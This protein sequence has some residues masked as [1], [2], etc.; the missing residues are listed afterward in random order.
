MSERRP[1]RQDRH[2][3]VTERPLTVLEAAEYLSVHPQTIYNLVQKGR[4]RPLR[5]GNRLRFT[6]ESLDR[7]MRGQREGGENA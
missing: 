5:V 6:R 3:A 1:S 4:L 2:P 7:Y